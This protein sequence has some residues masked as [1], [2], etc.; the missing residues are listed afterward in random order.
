LG[1]VGREGETVPLRLHPGDNEVVLA[2][3]DKAFGWGFRARLDSLGAV[4]VTP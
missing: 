2:V 3:V 4:R 1:V